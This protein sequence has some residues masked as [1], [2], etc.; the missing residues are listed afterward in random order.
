[1]G[2]GA[3]PR[4]SIIGPT[5]AAFVAV[6]ILVAIV[7]ALLLD[8]L[9]SM[10]SNAQ[11]AQRAERVVLQVSRLNRLTVDLETGIRGRLLSG[12]DEYLGPYR[13]AQRDIPGVEA[14]LDRLI[15]DPDQRRRFASLRQRVEGY[16]TG[17]AQLG[18]D[19][20]LD[21]TR[22][23]L[24][25]LLANGKEQLDELR[26]RFDTFRTAELALSDRQDAAADRAADRATVLGVG[27]LILTLAGL[28]ALAV[29]TV[30]WI[31]REARAAIARAQAEE[32]SRTK[33]TFLANM[34]HEIRTPL[35]GVIG[36]SDLLLDTDLDP[37]QR[38]YAATARSS[39]EQLLAVINDILDI[40]KIEAGHLELEERDFDL[41]E[42]VETTSDVVAATAH[43]KGLELSVLL[44]EDVPRAVRGDRGRVAQV[45]TNLLSNAVKFTP[46]GEVSVEVRCAGGPSEDGRRAVRFSVCDTG[47]G[48]AEKDLDRLFESFQ[49]ADVSTT[50][51]FGG[52]GLGLAISRQLAQLMGGDLTVESAVGRGSEFTAVIPFAPAEA[53]PAL[54]RPPVELRGLKVLAVDDTATNRRVLEAYLGSWGMRVTSVPDGVDALDALHRAAD[55]GEPFDVAIL[56][57]N[58]P[59][60]DGVELARRISAAPALRS[61][62]MVMLTSSGT[63]HAAAR[64]AG[65]TEFLTKPVR[66]SRLYDAIAS[67]MYQSTGV[68]QAR[69]RAAHDKEVGAMATGNGH[70]EEGALIL[71]AEDHDVN[72][73]L[74]EKL[75]DKR[76][77]RTIAA[78]DG[79]EAVRLAT[80]PG[81]DLV[82]MD[83]QMPELDGYAATR[84]IRE[85][86]TGGAR[87]PIVAMT[88]HA[89]AG[90][91]EKCLAAGMDDY[92]AKPL[93]PDEIDQM[94]A[95]WLPADGNG[96]ENGDGPA[97]ASVDPAPDETDPIDDARFGDLAR[98]FSPDV[99]REVVHAFID[100]TPSII[101]RIVLAAEGEDHVEIAQGAHRLKG[102]CLA[103]GAGELNDLADELERLGRDEAP[104]DALRD[105]ARR[106]ERS[107]TRTRRALR[108]RVG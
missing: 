42:M 86:E 4:G 67:A 48:I 93:R 60:M 52:T 29:F 33:S 37:E 61:V 36:M 7:F 98:D 100:S 73:I 78:A 101:E 59:R 35:N 70:G 102:G 75:L 20:S 84:R 87:L 77:H 10:R 8:G 69:V 16:R 27:G 12:S 85:R 56:D 106:L 66:Q 55:R 99:V 32:A 38:E 15:A 65:V 71:I 54:L 57:F 97:A 103:V 11:M 19:V 79:L 51:R 82:F 18:A 92:V 62:R 53:E 24:Q 17:W 96:H 89:M 95:R 45:L 1:M 63:G 39:G 6:G 76:G 108:E 25:G 74:M 2:K 80:A 21:S 43:G 88:A 40:S 91:R 41:R 34:S 26:T 49:Q 46:E 58:M 81:V 105:A 94:L 50:R 83:C 14:S 90:D 28:A 64:E 3:L 47:I 72:R 5:V 23:E 107:W 68:Q 9:S 44:A 13:D 31:R 30:R 22:V 104:G